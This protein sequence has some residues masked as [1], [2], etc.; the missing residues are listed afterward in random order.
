MSSLRRH[1]DIRLAGRAYW[2]SI[3]LELVLDCETTGKKTILD[4]IYQYRNDNERFENAF[5]IG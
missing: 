3:E 1:P 4:Q 5:V 2:K